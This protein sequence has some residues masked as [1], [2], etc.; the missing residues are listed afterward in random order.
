MSTVLRIEKRPDFR[1]VI[2]WTYEGLQP[3]EDKPL[4]ITAP[5]YIY[6]Q[7]KIPRDDLAKLHRDDLVTVIGTVYSYDTHKST[8]SERLTLIGIVVPERR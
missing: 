1:G 4:V 7:I 8:H 6:D 2:V 5:V 3:S